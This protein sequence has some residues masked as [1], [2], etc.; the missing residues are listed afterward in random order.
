VAALPSIAPY[1]TSA[2]GDM[3]VVQAILDYGGDRHQTVFVF[4]FRDGKVLRETV[5]WSKPFPAAASRAAWVEKTTAEGS[6]V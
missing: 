3:V 5:Y 2:S 6:T 4:E 1:R